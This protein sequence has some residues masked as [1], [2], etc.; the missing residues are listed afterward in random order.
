VDVEAQSRTEAGF[1]VAVSDS[2]ISPKRL[3]ATLPTQHL[4]DFRTVAE[5]LSESFEPNTRLSKCVVL[6]LK[7]PVTG[8]SALFPS[9]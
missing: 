3:F 9:G 7:A 4:S 6:S 5:A 8:A 1:K 2:S